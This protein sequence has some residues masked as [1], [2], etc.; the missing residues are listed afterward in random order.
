MGFKKK[1]GPAL[2]AVAA[3]SQYGLTK[4]TGSGDSR[5]IGL[6]DL[7]LD[8]LLATDDTGK[9]DTAKI[10]ALKPPIFA[11]LWEKYGQFLP[12]DDTIQKYLIREK[13]FNAGMVA[14]LVKDYRDTFDFAKLADTVSEGEADADKNAKNESPQTAAASDPETKGKAMTTPNV[15]QTPSPPAPVRQAPPPVPQGLIDIPVPLPSGVLAYYR[16]PQ[17][18][19]A[20][21]FKFYRSVLAAYEFGLTGSISLRGIDATEPPADE[22]KGES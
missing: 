20:A 21:D 11:H 2:R 19:S 8:Y 14:D 16:V 22:G 1:T 13:N 18:M 12:N 6:S 5:N 3:L 17:K 9:N 7:A 10:A 4:E 15:H